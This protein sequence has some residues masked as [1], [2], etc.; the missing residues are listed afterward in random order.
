MN[1]KI[2]AAFLVT[3]IFLLV[4][5]STKLNQPA[6]SPGMA[7]KHIEKGISSQADVFGNFGAPNFVTSTKSGGE[8]WVYS[9]Y[10][11]VNKGLT[12]N[13]GVGGVENSIAGGALGGGNIN[14]SSS[15]SVTLMI[16]FDKND[17]VTDYTVSQLQY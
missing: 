16:T 7:K 13:L 17:I 6:V 9:N 11:T 5:C 1:Q 10:A 14:S 8:L 15:R 12:L 3:L 4:S 2:T